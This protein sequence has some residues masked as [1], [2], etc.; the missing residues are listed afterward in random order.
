MA[1]FYFPS[2]NTAEDVTNL[3]GYVS[4]QRAEYHSYAGVDIVA[5]IVIPGEKPLTLGELQTISYSIH[6]ENSPIRFIGHVSP[7]GFGKG[8][9][10]I[11]GSMIFTQFNYYTFYKLQQYSYA[12]SKWNVFPVADMLPPFD[13]VLTFVNEYGSISKMKIMGITIVD[14]GSTMSID[15]L[16][17]EATYTYMAR[18]I[19]PLVQVQNTLVIPS[20]SGTQNTT[21]IREVA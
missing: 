11:A 19:Q 21:T 2:D 3:V 8:P 7:A 15:D 9:R 5:Q 16:V 1:D 18:N 10:T 4:P 6:R 17:T 12:I 13:V 14:E 20:S